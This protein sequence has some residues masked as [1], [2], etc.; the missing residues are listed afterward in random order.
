MFEE[1][2]RAIDREHRDEVLFLERQ[3]EQF[4]ALTE[5]RMQLLRTV[6]HSHP[7]SIRELADMVHRDVKNVFDDLRLLDEMNLIDLVKDGRRMKPVI[8][9]KIIVISLE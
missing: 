7:A 4:E 8:R 9:R 3:F 2:K 5:K 1:L 6:R